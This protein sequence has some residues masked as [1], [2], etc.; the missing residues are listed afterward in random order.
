MC[1]PFVSGWSPE[2]E[3]RSILNLCLGRLRPRETQIPLH[4]VFLSSTCP[5]SALVP[6]GQVWPMEMLT[7]L[8][9]PS[10][11]LLNSGKWACVG[12]ASFQLKLKFLLCCLEKASD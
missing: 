4:S 6:A 2:S 1:T 5:P 9:L 11:H 3:F 7:S 8:G 12:Q 10:E